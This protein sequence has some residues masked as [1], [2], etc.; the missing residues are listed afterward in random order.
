LRVDVCVDVNECLQPGLCEN[1]LCVNTRGSYSCVCRVGFILDASHGICIYVNECVQSPGVCS[2]GECVNTVGSYTCACP[3]GYRRKPAQCVSSLDVDECQLNPCSNSRC[4]NTPGSYR[5]VCRHGYRLTGNTCTDVDECKDPLR[6]P[7]Q[8]CINSQGSYR[9]VSCQP[10]YELLNRLCTGNAHLTIYNIF[11]INIFI[12]NF[13]L[14][15]FQLLAH[16]VLAYKICISIEI[17][18]KCL[19]WF[20]NID[21]CRQAPCSNGRC[22]NT[23]GSYRCVCHHGYKLQDN[24]CTDIN[25]CLEGDFCFSRGECV[26]TPGSYTCVCSRGFTL[27]DNR[28]ACL[29][30]SWRVQRDGLG[31][32]TGAFYWLLCLFLFS[33]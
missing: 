32:N 26:N 31:V 21:E 33:Q 15:G 1:G 29:G 24:T 30:E 20:I 2:V 5:C 16:L 18:A 9:C 8:E 14:F 23:P 13:C 4:E 25:E 10:G 22:E 27:S 28:T 7:G 3:S 6:C 11:K 19:K 17:K 12:C